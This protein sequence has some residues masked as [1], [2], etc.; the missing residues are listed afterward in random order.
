MM[1]MMV[2]VM[3]DILPVLGVAAKETKKGTSE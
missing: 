3:V 2:K 1:N